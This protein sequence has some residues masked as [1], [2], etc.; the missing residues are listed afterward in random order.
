MGYN[1]FCN[2]PV[3]YKEI[4]MFA[5]RHAYDRTKSINSMYLWV[6]EFKKYMFLYFLSI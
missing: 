4:K 3:L 2:I 6:V 1:I 5:C